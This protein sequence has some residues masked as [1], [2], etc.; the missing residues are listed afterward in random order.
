M[1]KII[2]KIP[3]LA[4]AAGKVSMVLFFISV[5]MVV[6][7]LIL[8]NNTLNNEIVNILLGLAT[9]CIGIIV[10]VAFV[11]YFLNKQQIKNEEKEEKNIILRHNRILTFLIER[12]IAYYNCVTVPID[13]RNGNYTEFKTTFAFSDMK[14]L[15]KTSLLLCDEI[16]EPAIKLFYKAEENLKEYMINML[17]NVDF[18]YNANLQE[19]LL[20]FVQSSIKYDSKSAIIGNMNSY[21]GSKKYID[22]VEEDIAEE[23]KHN[24]LKKAKDKTLGSNMM[25]SYI[26]LYNLLHIEIALIVKYQKYIEDLNK[27]NL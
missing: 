6:I 24:W 25:I 18:K 17:T 23:E 19:I 4:T 3:W 10:T 20:E 1:E 14:D 21:I 22:V 7:A 5:I 13:K 12:Y 2:K 8:S 15:Y 16:Y 27:K 9:N 26:N 11:Q